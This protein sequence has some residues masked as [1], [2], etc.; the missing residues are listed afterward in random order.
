MTTS[1]SNRDSSRI[2]Q[3]DGLRGIAV[4]FV[5]LFHY[6]NNAYANCRPHT[7]N[8]IESLIRSLTYWGWS[9]VDLFFILSGFLI[10]SIL[11]NNRQS[12]NYFSTFYVR[13]FS[14]IVP[15]YYI[16]LAV[17]TVASIWLASYQA[18]VFAHAFDIRWYVGFLQNFQMSM[19]ATFG[20]YGLGPT[21]SLAVEEQFY[22]IIPLV[23]YFLDDRK[24]L[25]FCLLCLFLAPIYRSLADNW[26]REYT[27][28]FARIDAPCYGVILALFVKNKDWIGWLKKKMIY[29]VIGLIG[30]L[31]AFVVL[32][33]KFLNHSVISLLFLGL[34]V[35]ALTLQPGQLL[36]RFLTQSFLVRMGKY[37]Y[38]IYLYHILVNG[39]MFIA[40]SNRINPDL[41]NYHGYMITLSSFA[42]TW[43]L[44]IISYRFVEGK[45]INW[46]HTFK[47]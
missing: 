22:L 4:L 7:L 26:Y 25:I 37:S 11:L 29:L 12:K 19:K 27:H 18:K 21:W 5:V 44:A 35:Y 41:E 39:L 16:L 36:H 6:L 30:L 9:G 24:V 46:S 20:S 13:R 23:I 47:Y 45:M 34:V 17:F 32:K 33:M 1:L 8:R 28:F 42:A 10:A 3:L 15:A 2:L 14:R 40:L 38:F 43:I 31:G